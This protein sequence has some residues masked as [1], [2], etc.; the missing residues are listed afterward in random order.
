MRIEIY[1]THSISTIKDDLP[2]YADI[3]KVLVF[4]RNIRLSNI[5]EIQFY[6]PSLWNF[7][8]FYIQGIIEERHFWRYLEFW[9]FSIEWTSFN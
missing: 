5:F 8:T 6:I 4:N 2:V 1:K 3:W 9:T 7:Q